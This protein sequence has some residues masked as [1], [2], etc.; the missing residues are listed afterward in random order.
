VFGGRH[1]HRFSSEKLQAE[2]E[3]LSGNRRAGALFYRPDTI[4]SAPA[5]RSWAYWALR[6][7]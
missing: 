2:S 7:Y 1:I 3:G 4:N 5:K 6:L